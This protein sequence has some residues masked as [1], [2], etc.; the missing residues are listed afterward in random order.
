MTTGPVKFDS[1]NVETP[2]PDTVT[3]QA[4]TESDLDMPV[5]SRADANRQVP[6]SGEG[7]GSVGDTA[8]QAETGQSATVAP[9]KEQ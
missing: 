4:A 2:S 8:N 3:D 7:E 9:Q 1:G 5:G 6:R